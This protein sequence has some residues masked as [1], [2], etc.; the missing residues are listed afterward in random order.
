MKLRWI[1]I[2]LLLISTAESF[3]YDDEITHLALTRIAVDRSV[4]AH[5]TV[6]SA[7]LGIDAAVDFFPNDDGQWQSVR[8][9]IP[10]GAVFE[11]AKP[12]SVAHFFNPRTGLGL[13]GIFKPS[14]DWALEDEDINR[15]IP[16]YSLTDFRD[17]LGLALTAA[18]ASIRE[19][20]FGRAFRSIGHVV[21][22]IEDMAQPQ[23][24]RDDAH[25][26][27]TEDALYEEETR[28]RFLARKD[29]EATAP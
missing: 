28:D 27:F 21:H 18:D 29:I 10:A 15:P 26:P 22:H 7:S 23:H 1:L 25:P 6:L 17:Y 13:G 2:A 4:L 19:K 5:P 8:E 9:L 11:D 20:G 3:A 12:N 16:Q 24:T 14:P